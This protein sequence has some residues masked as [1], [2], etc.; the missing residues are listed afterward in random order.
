MVLGKRLDYIQRKL[1]RR[2]GITMEY[3]SIF[4]SDLH[5]GTKN[6][7][8]NEIH[9]FLS[10]NK[11]D[12]LFLVG[13]I[14]DGWALRRKQYWPKEHSAII[15]KMIKISE[16]TKV[17]Y[18]PGNHDDFVRPF[19]RNAFNFGNFEI[20]NEYTYNSV[21]GRKILVL[22]GDKYDYWMRVPRPII[23]FFAHFTDWMVESKANKQKLKRYVRANATENM[24]RRRLKIG[25]YDAVICGHTHNPKV[26]EAYM[27]TGDWVKHC[28]A[29]VE[30]YDGTWELIQ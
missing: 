2:K 7:K 11:S 27:N 3:K 26:T 25:T 17:V 23:N 28:T 14:I 24:L 12:N 15:R 18:L 4:I 29:I 22:H 19:I 8:V 9:S 16:T 10:N 13:D 30:H 20:H 1:S 6:C 21:D 5:L